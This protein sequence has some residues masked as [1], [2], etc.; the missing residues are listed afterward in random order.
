LRAVAADFFVNCCYLKIPS[1][2]CI[3]HMTRCVL[4]GAQ[5]FR[6]ETLQNFYFGSGSRNPKLHS[7]SSDWFEYC[8][9]HINLLLVESFDLRQSNQYILVRV[10]PSC[11]HFTKMCL[12][13]VSVLQR[14]SRRYLTLSCGSSTFITW[15]VGTFF[16][17]WM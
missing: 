10:I 12:C 3:R 2:N 17:L 13:Q 11:F 14:C 7:V 9:I 15:T 6:L 4:S 1:N 16:F 5:G 8:F